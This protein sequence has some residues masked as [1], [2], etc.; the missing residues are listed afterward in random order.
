MIKKTNSRRDDFVR[1]IYQRYHKLLYLHALQL[2]KR[3]YH[4]EDRANDLMQDFYARLLEKYEYVEKQYDAQG[5]A[6]LFNMLRNALIDYH[7][8]EES[9][10]QMN[11]RYTL[12]LPSTYELEYPETAYQLSDSLSK[13]VLQQLS[14][15]EQQV[16]EYRV[17]ENLT[18][19]QIANRLDFPINTVGTHLRRAIQKLRKELGDNHSDSI[20]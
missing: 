15:Q 7:R 10:R 1:Y 5:I 11:Q 19:N 14:K 18:Y 16:L 8:S 2:C 20:E 3:F 6:Y 12:R 9:R 17:G 13:A 4:I